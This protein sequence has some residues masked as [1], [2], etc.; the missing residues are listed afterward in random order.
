M[1]GPRTATT[2][3]VDEA[4]LLGLLSSAYVSKPVDTAELLAVLGEWLPAAGPGRPSEV[5]A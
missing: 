2:D 4:V 1:E 3:G 5:V